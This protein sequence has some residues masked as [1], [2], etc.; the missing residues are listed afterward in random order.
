MGGVIAGTLFR[1]YLLISRGRFAINNNDVFRA[2]KL[3]GYRYFLRICIQ[4]APR[5]SRRSRCRAA[6]RGTARK[7]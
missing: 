5:L 6:A 2:I 7:S 4:H 3:D 1:L